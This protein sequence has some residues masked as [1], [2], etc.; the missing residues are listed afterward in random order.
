MH[1]HRECPECGT[2]TTDNMHTVFQMDSMIEV[3]VCNECSLE[4]EN[5]FILEHQQ[6][7]DTSGEDKK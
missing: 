6:I 1:S 5:K 7:T 4:Y 2:H 3:R